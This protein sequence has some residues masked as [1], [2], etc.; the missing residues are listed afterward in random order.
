VAAQVVIRAVLV[1]LVV[2]AVAVLPLLVSQAAQE[3]A[4]KDLLEEP[5]MSLETTQAAAEVVPVQ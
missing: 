1:A 5:V 2:P 4:I 3:R